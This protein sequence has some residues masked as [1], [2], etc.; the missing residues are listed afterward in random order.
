MCGVNSLAVKGAK[1]GLGDQR[2]C[3]REVLMQKYRR[4]GLGRKERAFLCF[5]K[6]KRGD[7][8]VV[9]L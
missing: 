5:A 8:E 9:N 3:T 1:E 7:S 4:F 2:V 6:K